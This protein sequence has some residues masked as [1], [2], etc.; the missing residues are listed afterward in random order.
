MNDTQTVIIKDKIFNAIN[1]YHMCFISRFIMVETKYW[2][3]YCSDVQMHWCK[4]STVSS[5]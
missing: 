1:K 3:D 5:N 4:S 2:F